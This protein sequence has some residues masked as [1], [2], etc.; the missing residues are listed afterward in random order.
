MLCQ[1]KEILKR[2]ANQASSKITAYVNVF[3][4]KLIVFLVI[5]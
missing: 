1:D 5:V 3:K 4:C 2:R